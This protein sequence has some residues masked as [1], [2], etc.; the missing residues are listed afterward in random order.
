MLELEPQVGV[1]RELA[2]AIVEARIGRVTRIEVEPSG[3]VALGQ[4]LQ[5]GALALGATPVRAPRQ[6]GH[7]ES[8]CREPTEIRSHTALLQVIAAPEP[9]RVSGMAGRDA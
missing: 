2:V 4:R 1:V 8:C 5:L 3:I 7:H 6:R 9:P